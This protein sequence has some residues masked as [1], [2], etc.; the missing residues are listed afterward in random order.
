MLGPTVLSNGGFETGDLT[1]WSASSAAVQAEFSGL[2][3]QFG[4][5]AA[6]LGPSSGFESLSQSVATTAGQ[7]YTVS[8]YV[9]GDPDASSNSLNVTWD[10]ATLLAQTDNF[11]GL[12]QYSFDVVGDASFSSTPLVFSYQTTAPA[13]SSTRSRSIPRP[14]R[15]PRARPETSPSR[16]SRRRTPIRRVSRRWPTITSARSRSI[17]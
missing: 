11:G 17:R 13:C 9:L 2:A 8:F 6:R 12:T 5:Y 10:G 15:R 7:H 14:V 16:T 1:G 4:N 3:A